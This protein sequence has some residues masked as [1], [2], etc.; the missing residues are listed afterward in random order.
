MLKLSIAAVALAFALTSSAYAQNWK[1]DARKDI[2]DARKLPPYLPPAAAKP[3]PSP[4]RGSVTIDG[5]TIVLEVDTN[6]CTSPDAVKKQLATFV[7]QA[8]RRMMSDEKFLII[9]ECAGIV[10]KG[11]LRIEER[12]TWGKQPLLCVRPPNGERCLWITA[13]AAKN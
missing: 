7:V 2:E 10:P 6:A 8:T 3:E 13:G 11:A 1:S 5:D 12:E 9:P 4:G